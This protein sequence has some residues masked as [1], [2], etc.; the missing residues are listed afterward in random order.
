M[1]PPTPLHDVTW[2]TSIT[3]HISAETRHFRE[4]GRREAAAGDPGPAPLLRFSL[5]VSVEFQPLNETGVKAPHLTAVFSDSWEFSRSSAAATGRQ[6]SSVQG[7]RPRR[8]LPPEA[9]HRPDPES[10]LPHPETVTLWPERPSPLRRH[11]FC[12]FRE[13]SL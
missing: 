10:H 1:E 2:C 7:T 8:R 13:N 6:S 9:G 4:C 5:A 11:C 3:G 12:V